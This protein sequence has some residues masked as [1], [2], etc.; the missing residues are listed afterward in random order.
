[1]DVTEVVPAELIP[2][3]AWLGKQDWVS[4]RMDST[5]NRTIID[6]VFILPTAEIE[7]L[8]PRIV[9]MLDSCSTNQVGLLSY[10]TLSKALAN[11]PKVLR[12]SVEQCRSLEHVD[13]NISFADYRQ[14]YPAVFV[15]LPAEYRSEL[16]KRFSLESPKHVLSYHDP[17][18]GYLIVSAFTRNHCNDVINV[19]PP[20]PEFLTIEE[21]LHQPS[22]VGVDIDL[23]EVVQRLALNFS[24]MLTY[25][26]VRELGAVSDGRL[27][28]LVKAARNKK[29]NKAARA[30]ALIDTMP[31]LIGFR[32]EID[33]CKK[34]QESNSQD[35]ENPKP[36]ELLP[37]KPHW[38]R[39]HFRH[40]RVGFGRI[41][42]RLIFIKPVLVNRLLFGGDEKDTE[43]VYTAQQ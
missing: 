17:R 29:R 15:E 13:L 21:G 42:S 31:K 43:V 38:R 33:F 14:P 37:R 41:E 32:Q 24:L 1:M 19:I 8:R 5:E 2:V 10:Y 3:L 22:D 23:A 9:N 25:L 7:H 12:P 28:R 26:G 18:T 27:K 6:P 36:D 40:Q 35:S 16:T 20:R 39:G 34:R 11:G 4:Y 30:A